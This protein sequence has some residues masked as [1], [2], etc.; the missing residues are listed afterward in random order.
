M[1]T[2]APQESRLLAAVVAKNAV[3]SSWRKTMGSREWSRVPGAR[4]RGWGGPLRQSLLLGGS[5]ARTSSLCRMVA[6]TLLVL[7]ALPAAADDEKGY[8]RATALAVLLGDPSDRVALQA[9]LLATNIARFDFPSPWASLLRDLAAAAAP[10]G[11]LPPAGRLRALTA[12]KHVLR[13]LQGAR[14]GVGLC[15]G[16][17]WAWEEPV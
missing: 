1:R 13:A 11:G 2:G 5:R 8:V 3:G 9:T 4:A 17:G 12:L 10:G 7:C 14:G 6:L 15:A 16:S